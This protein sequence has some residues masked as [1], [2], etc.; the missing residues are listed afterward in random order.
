MHGILQLKLN[1]ESKQLIESKFSIMHPV[2]CDYHVTLMIGANRNEY[3]YILGREY[4]IV[5]YSEVFNNRVQAFRVELPKDLKVYCQNVQPHITI[6]RISEATAAES[7]GML[8]S[9][10]RN[11]HDL[12]FCFRDDRLFL[13]GKIDFRP[14]MY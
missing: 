13:T 3:L 14:F 12:N 1:E 9:R 2:K 8:L 11:E 5:A 6:S 10:S 7:N 4:K